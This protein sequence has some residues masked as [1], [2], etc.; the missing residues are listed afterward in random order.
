MRVA[1][2]TTWGQQ[3]GISTYTEELATALLEGG[4]VHPIALAPAEGG[5]G[6]REVPGIPWKTVWTRNCHGL[7]EQLALH[8]AGVDV[9]H[10]Q[11]EDGLFMNPANFLAAV[12]DCRKLCKVVVTMHT[13][14]HYGTWLYSGFYDDLCKLAHAVIVHTPEA[15]VSLAHSRGRTA[16]L[17]RIPHGT[18]L[19]TSTLLPS[20]FEAAR[21]RGVALLNLPPPLSGMILSREVS[22]GLVLGFQGPSKNPV[23]T[24]RGFATAVARRLAPRAALV[25]S[26]EAADQTWWSII[27]GNTVAT[28]YNNRIFYNPSFVAADQ[29]QYVMAAADWG[30]LN[31]HAWVLSS[32]GA[33][34]LY[35]AHGVPIACA[36]RPIYHEALQAGAIPFDLESDVEVP[37]TSLINAVGALAAHVD[38]REQVASDMRDWAQATA[39]PRIG[40]KHIELYHRVLEKRT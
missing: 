7:S 15:L 11:H 31:T 24:I 25:I 22:L 35:A 27:Q 8:L 3:C 28:G 40:M 36:N 2:V 29:V 14:R 12:Q 10:F 33:A 1:Y 19:P 39:W 6:I 23:G 30:V 16:I 17:T 21:E 4:V 9:V 5:V 26:G 32:S 20:E 34:H 37:S 13:V 38:V 18:P